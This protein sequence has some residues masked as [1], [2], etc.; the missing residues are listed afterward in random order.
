VDEC[1][2][3]DLRLLDALLDALPVATRGCC[4]SAIAISWR[5]WSPAT[6]SAHCAAHARNPRRPRAAPSSPRCAGFTD[7]GT[8][9]TPAIADAIAVLRHSYRFDATSGIGRL[10]AAVNAG[11]HAEARGGLATGDSAPRISAATTDASDGAELARR[12]AMRYR[13]LAAAAIA[14]RGNPAAADRTAGAAAA[15]IPRVVRAARR[16][17][18]GW[19]TEPRTRAGAGGGGPRRSRARRTIAGRPLL[20]TRNDS[21]AAA[22]QRRPRHRG[23]GRGRPHPLAVFAHAVAG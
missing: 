12:C 18:W 6:C 5:P 21:R 23:R 11:N 7:S 15:A 3:V 9:P 14:A 22:V 10:A 4:C 16:A 1:S 20:V 19:R 13:E 17:E 2:M 8:I